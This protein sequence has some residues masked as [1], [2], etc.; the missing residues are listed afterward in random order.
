MLMAKEIIYL[1]VGTTGLDPRVCAM[2]EVSALFVRDDEIVNQISLM[3]NPFTYPVSPVLEPKAMEMPNKVVSPLQN[4]PN[5]KFQFELFLHEIK[6]F[7]SAKIQPCGYNVSFDIGFLSKWFE[8]NGDKFNNY[9]SHKNLDVMALAK[10]LKYF[11]VY[12]SK[13]DLLTETCASLN[14]DSGLS[15]TSMDG[16]LA[17]Y[18]LH[19]KLK[20]FIKFNNLSI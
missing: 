15:H 4:N 17:I 8:I 14:V 10:H 2:T 13:S 9:F 12:N 7:S 3:I 1:Y 16:V 19:N 18:H 20:S 5:Q 11:G 6:K